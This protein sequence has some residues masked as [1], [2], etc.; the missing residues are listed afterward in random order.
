MYSRDE[1]FFRDIFVALS[2][3]PSL[4]RTLRGG[5]NNSYAW[6]VLEALPWRHPVLLL[7]LI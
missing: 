1:S 5:A 2:S 6:R 3:P 4:L 7:I